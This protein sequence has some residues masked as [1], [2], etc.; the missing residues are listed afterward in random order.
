M[1]PE[2]LVQLADAWGADLRRWPESEQAAAQ[3]LLAHDAG[4]QAVLARAADLD[5]MLDLHAVA[6][7]DARLQ[8]AVL[9]GAPGALDDQRDQRN[10][11]DRLDRF[12]Q[13]E[14]REQ[15]EH[16]DQRDQRD[17]RN[18]RERPEGQRSGWQ[19]PRHWWWPG[20]GVA[21]V[22]LA[23]TVVGAMAVAT[24][25]STVAPAPRSTGAGGTWATT[26]FDGS[27]AAEWSEE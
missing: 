11:L 14:Q 4:L 6:P 1:T 7:P 26:V 22:G 17:Q 18:Q 21:G 3:A 8:R 12:D 23:G 5:A 2:R 20:A 19:F 13:S 9:A 25:L 24:A 15:R 27:S 16:H 10:R